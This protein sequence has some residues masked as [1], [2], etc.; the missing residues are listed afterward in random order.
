MAVTVN[1]GAAMRAAVMMGLVAVVALGGCSRLGSLAAPFQSLISG[2][3]QGP[4]GRAELPPLVPQGAVAQVADARALA[5]SVTTVE[6]TPVTGGRLLTVTAVP[7]GPGAYNAELVQL[8]RDGAVLRY[9]VRMSARAA[10]GPANP[11]V[12]PVARR[13]AADDLTGVRRITVQ[14]ANGLRSV[15]I[16]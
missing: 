3:D 10:A 15:A 7:P 4:K 9:A 11:A 13:I 12:V 2:G 14:S 6:L 1:K 16:R 8:D 5:R